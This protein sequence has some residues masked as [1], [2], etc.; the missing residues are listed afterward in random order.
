ML[1]WRLISLLKEFI[2]KKVSFA[3]KECIK[4]SKKAK[5]HRKRLKAI[6]K[7]HI[8]VNKEKEVNLCEAGVFY[9]AE[10]IF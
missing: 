2:W 1:V 8:D 5:R 9:A 10:T 7:Y 3:Y 4:K 6:R